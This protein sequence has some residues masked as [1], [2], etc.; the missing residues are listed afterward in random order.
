MQKLE[1]I[2]KELYDI[3]AIIN[4]VNPPPEIMNKQNYIEEPDFKDNSAN[5]A[6]KIID[7]SPL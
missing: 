5:Q 6:P 1:L 2:Q 4:R 3:Q 7:E